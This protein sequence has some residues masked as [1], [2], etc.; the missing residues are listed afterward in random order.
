LLYINR[1]G[2]LGVEASSSIASYEKDIFTDD[3]KERFLKSATVGWQSDLQSYHISKWEVL[4]ENPQGGQ[5]INR[6][7]VVRQIP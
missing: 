1:S 4:E 2:E 6:D 7:V 3:V 5:I